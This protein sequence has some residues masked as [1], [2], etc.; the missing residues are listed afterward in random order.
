MSLRVYTV[1]TAPAR[2]KR[3]E[4][5][6]P[7]PELVKEGFSWPAFFLGIAWA[8]YHRLWL[9]AAA[10]VAISAVLGVAFEQFQFGRAGSGLVFL[11][12][13]TL[14]GLMGNDW[15]RAALRRRGY[16]EDGVVTAA[17]AETAL[18]RYLDLSAIAG[19]PLRPP[20]PQARPWGAADA[21]PWGKA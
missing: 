4:P 12:L 18:R 15:R 19:A 16:G 9:A 3:W 6:D 2:A 7:L 10:L 5:L 8:L 1:H 20:A 14:T 21:G 13:A 17:D 11:A